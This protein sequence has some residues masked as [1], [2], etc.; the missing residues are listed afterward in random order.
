MRRVE[1]V[2]RVANVRKLVEAECQR[3]NM[4]NSILL[5]TKDAKYEKILTL[6]KQTSCAGSERSIK[7]RKQSLVD[8]EG[9]H[10]P[11]P[12]FYNRLSND[13]SLIKI[14]VFRD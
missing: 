7:I 3:Q 11:L 14:D 9:P 1:T 12:F 13:H 4:K 10:S 2:K 5:A 8:N 6:M